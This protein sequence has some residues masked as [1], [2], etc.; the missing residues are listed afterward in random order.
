MLRVMEGGS[1]VPSRVECRAENRATK[2]LSSGTADVPTQ[3]GPTQL[4]DF[5]TDRV[6]R[7]FLHF[8]GTLHAPPI[9]YLKS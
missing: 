5:P 9:I 2:V 3:T 4:S 1:I 6:A 7:G 8:R